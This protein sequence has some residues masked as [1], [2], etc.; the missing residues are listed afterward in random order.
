MQVRALNSIRIRFALMVAVLGSAIAAILVFTRHAHDHVHEPLLHLSLI[1]V[2]SAA[3]PGAV[4]YLMAGKLTSLIGELKKSTEAIAAGDFD[5]AIDVNCS[6]EIGGLADSF[7][8]MV[9]RLN[10][11]ILR[12]N[13]LAYTDRV[14]ELPNRAVIN[15][16]LNRSMTTAVSPKFSGAVMFID[17]DKFKQV[18]DTLG[19]DAGDELLRQSSLRILGQGFDRTPETIDNCMT[20]FGELCDRA[21][22]DIVFVRF[23]GDEFVALLPG[24]TDRPAIEVFANR[25]VECLR[26]PFRISNTDVTVGASIGI[27]ITPFDT[28]DP[29]ELLNFADL[30]MYAAK[31]SGRGRF[32]F[33]DGTMREGALQRVN[34]ERELRDAIPRGEIITFFQPQMNID[35]IGISGVEALARWNHPVRGILPPRDFIEVAEQ[36]GL[37]EGLGES[38]ML[39][40]MRQCAAWHEAGNPLKVSIN[41]S[42]LQF[43]RSG[44]VEKVLDGLALTGAPPNLIEIEITES[45]ALID[46]D[47]TLNILAR[48]RAAGLSIAIDDFG[49]GFSNLSLLA[50]LPFDTLKVDKSLVDSIG[51]DARGESV[52]KAIIDMGHDLGHGIVAEGVETM[53]QLSFLQAQGCDIVQGYLF[54]RPMPAESLAAWEASRGQSPVGRRIAET[55]L[56]WRNA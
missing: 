36:S 31:Q 15:H 44:F 27:A 9:A 35:G 2:G 20:P 12:M 45:A 37:I 3:I 51:F 30:A 38:V 6:C 13:V 52:I 41:V 42:Q 18:N 49:C 32:A 33:F 55:E 22:T 11:N 34:I 16:I 43:A 39:G 24:I 26:E 29:A 47:H 21:P 46:P 53:K 28:T 14:T 56:R 7:R 40:A 17:L 48:L 5:A 54:A 4:T 1:I 10:A 8:T 19:H 50:K 23:A 25:I